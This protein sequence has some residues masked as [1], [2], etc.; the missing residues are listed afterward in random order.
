MLHDCP[1]QP[2]LASGLGVQPKEQD[3][4]G[5]APLWGP[6]LTALAAAAEVP[7]NIIALL[8]ESDLVHGVSDKAGLEKPTGVLAGLP[9]L[10]E[11]FHMV[12]EPVDHVRAWGHP[13][14]TSSG[15]PPHLPP[16]PC[17][18]RPQ[19]GPPQP[20]QDLAIPRK[21]LGMVILSHMRS[22]TSNPDSGAAMALVTDAMSVWTER[23]RPSQPAREKK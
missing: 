2:Y 17:Q 6:G 3:E 14:Q 4:A 15:S 7:K 18:A 20:A 12:V 10:G 16:H 1:R 11:A 21:A 23:P 22:R 13:E 9:P 8:G 5:Q 19:R